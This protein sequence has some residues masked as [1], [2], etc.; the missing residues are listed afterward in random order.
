MKLRGLK[1][2]DLESRANTLFELSLQGIVQSSQ[3]LAVVLTFPSS[4][5]DWIV[6]PHTAAARSARAGT[7]RMRRRILPMS[8]RRLVMRRP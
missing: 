3:V 1:V 4:V 7:A 2:I 6:H 8:V 5:P